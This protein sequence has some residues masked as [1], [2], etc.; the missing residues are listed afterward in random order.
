[1][2]TIM[3]R[4][5]ALLVFLAGFSFWLG[6]LLQRERG[7]PEAFKVLLVGGRAVKVE[8]AQTEAQRQQG[9]SDRQSLCSDCGLLF[10]FDQPGL[11]PFWMK[12]MHFD[13]DI[14]WIRGDKVVEI[15]HQAKA[16][17]L[18]EYDSP[19]TIYQSQVLVDKVLE[20]NAGWCLENGV[21]VGDLVGGD[22]KLD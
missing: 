5:K 6:F 22:F 12:R 19:K 16:P 1:M 7:G 9:L 21:E 15:T 10:I 4:K 17:P 14:I 13:I 18:E 20:V 2:K 3:K 8:V 11:Y